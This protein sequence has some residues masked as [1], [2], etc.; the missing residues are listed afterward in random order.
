M[1]AFDTEVVPNLPVT[2]A[3]VPVDWSGNAIRTDLVTATAISED[4]GIA[5]D[6]SYLPDIEGIELEWVDGDILVTWDH[7]TDSSVRMY[8]IYISDSDFSST[9]EADL[10]GE[11]DVS[12][13]FVISKL[14][15]ESLTN[16][17][18]WWIGVSAVDDVFNKEDITPERIGAEDQNSLKDDDEGSSTV[19]LGEILSTNNIMMMIGGLIVVILLVFVLRGG[20]RNGKSRRNKDYELQEATWGIQARD[21]WDDIGNFAGQTTAPVAPPPPAIKPVVQNDIF[22]AADRIQQPVQNQQPP[23]WQPP[24]PPQQS[25]QNQIDTSFLDDLL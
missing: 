18:S 5:G 22:A 11:V 1:L 24:N 9:T 25:R 3:V 12:N 21:G 15:Y 16:E 17:S 23:A 20:G 14:D 4:D 19:D 6:G 10:V 13:S 7:T 2:V 8:E